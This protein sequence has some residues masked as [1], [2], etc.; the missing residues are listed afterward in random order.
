M[1]NCHIFLLSY[2]PIKGSGQFVEIPGVRN[3]LQP[4]AE[5]WKYCWMPEIDDSAFSL[6]SFILFE[7]VL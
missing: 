2:L 3:H 4:I 7:S 5:Q 6:R 1:F